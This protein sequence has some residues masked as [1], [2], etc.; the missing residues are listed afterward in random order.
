MPHVARESAASPARTTV[1]IATRNRCSEVLEHLPK[2]EGPVVLLDNASTDDTV[3]AVAARHPEVTVIPLK[4]NL[5]ATART[6]GARLADT[7]FVAFSDDDSWYAPGALRLAERVFDRHPR[8][9]LLAGS[10]LVGGDATPD[11]INEVL[12]DSPLPRPVDSPGPALLGFVGCAAIVR[13]SAFLAVGGFDG[14]VRFPGEEER[15]ALDLDDA[16]WQLIHLPEL[17]VHH[18]PS[19]HR[20]NDETRQ[21]QLQRSRLLTAVMRW[22]RPD[23]LRLAKEQCR[24]RRGRRAVL[25]AL[26]RIPAALARRR[27]VGSA[28]LG[29]LAL[30]DQDRNGAR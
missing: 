28:T 10:I 27:V 17:V 5:G 20:S 9:G 15:L 26:P 3:A 4:R 16:G 12:A 24:T 14:V 18:H 7:P 25:E 23:A 8:V 29:R 19:P 6:L 22:P 2:H 11:P 13:R 21:R 1:V 30:L